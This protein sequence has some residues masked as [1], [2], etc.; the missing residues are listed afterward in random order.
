MAG[1]FCKE[2]IVAA[3]AYV[4]AGMDMGAPLA[5]DDR[6]GADQLAIE[7]LDAQPPSPAVPSVL[8]AAYTFFMCHA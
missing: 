8:G 1:D 7:T 5:H 3:D 4:P 6:P 2:G